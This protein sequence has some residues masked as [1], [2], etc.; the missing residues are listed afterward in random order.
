MNL[1]NLIGETLSDQKPFPDTLAIETDLDG[2]LL[3]IKA[4]RAQI[5]RMLSNMIHNAR[6]A[7]QD[8]G[9]IVIK[10]EN[11]YADNIS[12]A[13]G[14]VPQGEYVKLTISDTGHGIS[15]DITQKIFDPFFTTKTADKKRGSG[16]GLSVVDAVVKDHNGYIDLESKIGSGTIFYFYFPVTR[17]GIDD[18]ESEPIPG[19]S[20]KVLVVDDDEM[21]RVVTLKILNS[22][23]YKTLAVESG[24]KAVDLLTREP[25]DLL[26]LDM[27][28]PPGI[29]GA[30]TFE[31]TL[32]INPS[33]K[34]LIVSGYAETDRVQK[35]LQ[36]GAGAFIRKPLTRG[37]LARALR[38][39]LT[40]E[41]KDLSR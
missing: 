28:M 27:I 9:H 4:G 39:E 19:G 31:K 14:N 30:E 6:D 1:N 10:S 7:T 12:V 34:A 20:E 38:R 29:D 13:Y 8:I 40:R 37:K 15:E 33:Q 24:E 32:E 3:N 18:C 21:Q 17:E 36:L 25:Q 16:L 35:A 23:G 5:H 22:L 2:E 41:E 26:V 11:F